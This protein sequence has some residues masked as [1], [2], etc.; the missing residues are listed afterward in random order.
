MAAALEFLRGS[1]TV[2]NLSCEPSRGPSGSTRSRGGRPQPPLQPRFLDPGRRV[3]RPRTRGGRAQV[4]ALCSNIG[5]LLWSGIVDKSK[6]KACARHLMGPRLFSGWHPHDGGTRRPVQPDRVPRGNGLAL[7]LLVRRMGSATVRLQGGGRADR[8][9]HPR[10]RPLLPGS[11]AGGVRGVLASRH[12]VPGPVP[13]VV[14][15][16]SVVH[17]PPCSFSARCSGS[18]RAATTWWW[19]RRCRSGSGG[20]SWSTSPA[21]GAARTPSREGASTPAGRSASTVNSASSPRRG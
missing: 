10:R 14:Q 6:A 16:A 2:K 15:S 5:H 3:F 19:T 13:D 12:E 17:R 1:S 20:S 18:S 21:G 8:G 4:D 9:R 7:R 11:P